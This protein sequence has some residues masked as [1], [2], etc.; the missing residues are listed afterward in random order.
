MQDTALQALFADV[1]IKESPGNFQKLSKFLTV[2]DHIGDR[3]TKIEFGLYQLVICLGVEP[4]RQV[5]HMGSTVG[6]VKCKPLIGVSSS[7]FW[8]GQPVDRPLPRY[9]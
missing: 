7:V 8:L 9:Q 5:V 2:I 4:G 6:L 1:V 3:F